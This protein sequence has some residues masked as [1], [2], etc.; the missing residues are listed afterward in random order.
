MSELQDSVVP[1]DE[2]SEIEAEDIKSEAAQED[3]LPVEFRGK[4]S[5]EIAKQALY[6]RKEMGRQANELGEIRKLADELIRSQIAKPK[7]EG[8]PQE[9]D[10]FENPQEAIRRAVETNP[11]LLAAKQ[12]ANQAKQEHAKLKLMQLHPD[13]TQVVQDGEFMDWVKSSKVRQKLFMD[14][15]AY[16]VDAADELL[17]TFK[18]LRTVKKRV[19][20]E[21]ET[22]ARKETVA[23]AS[24]DSSGSGESSKKVYRRADLIQLRIRDPQAFAARKSE[25]DRA[26]AEG[27]VR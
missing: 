16:D 2:V 5:S 11:D 27:R 17:G 14:A 10:F 13:F 25:I 3:E 21:T 9:V 6:F 22:K 18:A 8:K 23:N 1:S 20:D 4:S 12:M 7:E 24:V 19:V 15:E 26:Y